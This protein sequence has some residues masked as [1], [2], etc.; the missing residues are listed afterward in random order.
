VGGIFS[1]AGR[2][3]ASAMVET[4][5]GN[6]RHEDFCR[7]LW[8]YFQKAIARGN[9]TDRALDDYLST[10]KTLE[11]VEGG[12]GGEDLEDE[13]SILRYEVERDGEEG[14]DETLVSEQ[15]IVDLEEEDRVVR[16]S[17]NLLVVLGRALAF[18]YSKT[19][20]N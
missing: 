4:L 3:A 8:E 12:K 5:L 17:L 2:V 13:D 9:A 19:K 10:F 1:E 18:L 15:A 14:D 20:L 11:V 7:P 16:S 6:S